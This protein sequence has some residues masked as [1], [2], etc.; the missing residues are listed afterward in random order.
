MGKYDY[1]PVLAMNKIRGGATVAQPIDL[2][3]PSKQT[4]K[5]KNEQNGRPKAAQVVQPSEKPETKSKAVLIKLKPSTHQ[6]AT[7]KFRNIGV[8]FNDGVHQLLD[9]F[10]EGELF[11][12]SR[13]TYEKIS[14]VCKD[15]DVGGVITGLIEQYLEG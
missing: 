13:D 14:M 3:G 9:T 6:K 12:L 15:K 8:N 7:K 11:V 2:P 4:E 5:Q 1:D 10:G